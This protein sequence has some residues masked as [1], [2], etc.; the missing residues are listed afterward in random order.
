MTMVTIANINKRD[1]VKLIIA[2]KRMLQANG[3]IA[4]P[5]IISSKIEKIVERKSINKK[6]LEKLKSSKI[7]ALA[8]SNY[9]E[10][11][12]KIDNEILSIIAT[13]LSSDFRIISY[14]EPNVDGI[15]LDK[16]VLSDYIGEEI[17][18]Y[19]CIINCN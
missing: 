7:Y 10:N 1:Y 18:T 3:L 11:D 5:F 6:E 2:A 19:I 14:D 16:S 4:M 9:M 13:V 12:T 17:L 8:K 15:L